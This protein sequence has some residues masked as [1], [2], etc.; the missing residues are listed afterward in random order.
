ME[1]FKMSALKRDPA[2]GRAAG[3]L[4]RKGLIPGIIYGHGET[5]LPVSLDAEQVT[6]HLHH[7]AHLLDL[8]MDGQVSKLLIKEVQ[9]NHLGDTVMHID[10][11]RVSLDE[12]VEVTVPLRFRG[13]PVGVTEDEGILLTPVT[14]LEVECPVVDIPNEIRIN[15]KEL[16]IDQSILVKDIQLPPGVVAMMP[17]DTV[18]ATVVAPREEE[19]AAAVV[20]GEAP[21]QP[22][23]IAK[24]KVE[25]EEG[26]E[27]EKKE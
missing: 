8:E 22:E 25:T 26:E 16:R 5:P 21:A 4:R 24:G 19:E 20:E 2:G 12:R 3:R 10:L 17:P 15:V 1:T 9:Y 13:E 6:T 14:D 18:V 27:P 23:V 7:G 11:A